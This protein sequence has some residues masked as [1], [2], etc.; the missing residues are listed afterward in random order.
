MYEALVPTIREVARA[1]G[2]AIG[3]HGSLTRDLDLIAAPWTDTAV[4]AETL[5]EAIRVA[6]DGVVLTTSPAP[7]PERKPHGRR[8]WSINLGGAAYIDLSVMPLRRR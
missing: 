6:V 5:V 8:A 1:V 2:Y 3:A 7:N 4:E